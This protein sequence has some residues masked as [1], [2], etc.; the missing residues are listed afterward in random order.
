[1]IARIFRPKIFTGWHMLGVM[2]L[3]FGTIISVNLVMATMASRSWTGLVVENSYVAG[4]QFNERVA[5]ARAQ[6]A[7]GWTGDLT[8][9]DGVVRYRLTDSMGAPIVLDE[10][11]V[12]FRR[13]AYEAED[14]TVALTKGA[15]GTWTASPEVRDGLWLIDVVAKVSDGRI[16]A[17]KQNQRVQVSG[18][19]IK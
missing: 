8:L 2:F 10:A 7:L 5:E 13:P 18:G 6:D 1:M 19:T 14:M 4:Q 17:F 12:T 3:F 15:N 11:S 16:P 9:K